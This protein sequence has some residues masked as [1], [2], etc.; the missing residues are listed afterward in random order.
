MVVDE[1]AAEAA[2]LGMAIHFDGCEVCARAGAELADPH[3][4]CDDGRAA[5]ERWLNED[6][7]VAEAVKGQ[8]K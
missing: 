5:L 8:A 1:W 6:F 4:L 3:T 7:R 2:Y